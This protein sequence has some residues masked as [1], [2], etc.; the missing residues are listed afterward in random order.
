MWL[1][2]YA[3]HCVF[4]RKQYL[5]TRNFYNQDGIENLG[6]FSVG[7]ELT[8]GNTHPENCKDCCIKG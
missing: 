4:N 5:N 6:P 2:Q 8:A 1:L 7:D 3:Y